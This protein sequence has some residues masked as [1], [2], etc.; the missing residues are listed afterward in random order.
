M[1]YTVLGPDSQILQLASKEGVKNC[2]EIGC[3]EGQTSNAIADNLPS[4]GKLICIDPLLD[5]YLSENL[6]EQNAIDNDGRWKYFSGQYDKFIYNT[7][8]HMDS[9]KIELV[10]KTSSDAFIA[11][12]HLSNTIDFCFIDGDH[13]CEAV[14]L[15]GV[16]CL[17]LCRSGG[18]ILFDD[19]NWGTADDP[20]TTK[21]G[22]DMFLSEYS[23]SIKVISIG[24]RVLVEKI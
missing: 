23:Q 16:G 9:G 21:R 19:Y 6:N 14:Y 3:F 13:R 7:K 18:K 2:I 20:N 15:D 17:N 1:K 8:A 22:I 5:C 11:L 4:D 24:G 12:G 10:R